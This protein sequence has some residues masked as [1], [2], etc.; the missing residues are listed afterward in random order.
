MLTGLLVLS[1]LLDPT[2]PD[3][4]GDVGMVGGASVC[5]LIGFAGFFAV[6]AIALPLGEDQRNR[7][8][9]LLWATT[10]GYA[11]LINVFAASFGSAIQ[12]AFG[13]YL[14]IM[15]AGCVAATGA[16]VLGVLAIAIAVGYG[17]RRKTFLRWLGLVGL[18]IGAAAVYDPDNFLVGGV[19]T[20]LVLAGIVE[21]TVGAALEHPH[22]PEPA[23]AACLV[24]GVTAVV[25]WVIYRFIRLAMR[26]YTAT[27]WSAVKSGLRDSMR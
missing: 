2:L 4:V 16:A 12:Y 8:R 9:V 23:L 10:L 17:S 11:V 25:L 24:A 20:G 7:A 5:V 3:D 18:A 13:V 1:G 14:P 26:M 22:V 27:F 19:I 6:R 21:V 15:V